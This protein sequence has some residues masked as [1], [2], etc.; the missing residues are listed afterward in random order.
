MATL[1]QAVVLIHGIGEQVPM[2]TLRGFV[3]AVWTTDESVRNPFVPDQVWSKPDNVSQNYELRRLT[4]AEGKSGKRTDFFE[5]YW[6]DLMEGT[7]VEHVKAWLKLLL[8]RSPRRVPK[9][10]RGIWWT[11]A[12]FILVAVGLA[13][14]SFFNLLPVKVAGLVGA[15]STV[16]TGLLLWP[17]KKV[18]GDAARYLHV[19]PPNIGK[20]RIIREA[21]IQLLQRLHDSGDY[22]RII[23]VG[24][25]LGT[26]IGYDILTQLWPRYNTKHAGT[27]SAEPDPQEILAAKPGLAADEFQA[28][29]TTYAASLKAA[30]SPWLITDFITMGSP[31]AHAPFLLTRKPEEFQT[32]KTERELP[33]CPPTLETVKKNPRFC[34]PLNK[35]WVPNH[36]AVFAPT[37]WTNLYF[38]CAWTLKGDVVGGPLQPVFGAGIR[39][40]PVTTTIQGGLLN[41]THYWEFPDGQEEAPSHIQ[42]LRAA[43]RI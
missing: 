23:L 40:V 43:I 19:A 42:A 11:V 37:R 28:G 27:T 14:A 2:D 20:R 4:T 22:D 30:G 24:H 3:K 29:Q 33:T 32:K 5:F 12:L 15:I 31:L 6:A 38:P 34:Y 17:I 1:K 39:D 10:L 35:T 21:G 9:Q 36:A 7:E 13:V 16:L 25:S 41:H 26:V 8:F 18:A